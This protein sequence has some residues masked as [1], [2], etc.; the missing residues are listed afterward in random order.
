MEQHIDILYQDDCIAVCVKPAGVDSQNGMPALLRT[1]LGGEA[2]CVHRLDRDVGGVMV[3]ARNAEAAA[4]LGSAIAGGRLEKE[5]LAVC[6]GRPPEARGEMRDLLFHDAQRNKTFVV[7]RQR[8]GVK[9]AFLDYQ[10][11]E[12]LEDCS[13]VRVRLHTGRSHQIRVQFASRGMPLLGDRKYGSRIKDFGIALWSAALSF[14]HPV[15]GE[16]LRFRAPPSKTDP[17]TRFQTG[18]DTDA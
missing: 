15:T 7:T 11:L 12:A 17:W 13:L 16:T 6:A 18:G 1:Q 9:E 8:R 4:K 5:Y 14:P 10:V 3:Y 2:Y